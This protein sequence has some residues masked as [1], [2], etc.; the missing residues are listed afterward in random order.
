M[1]VCVFFVIFSPCKVELT[2]SGNF[3]TEYPDQM[4]VYNLISGDLCHGRPV[5]QKGGTNFLVMDDGGS[6][7]VS[8]RH[9][10][11]QAN[12]EGFVYFGTIDNYYMNMKL[13]TLGKPLWAHV[14]DSVDDITKD[15]VYIE[16]PNFQIIDVCEN[17]SNNT[18]IAG[19]EI[20]EFN[21]ESFWNTS[22]LPTFAGMYLS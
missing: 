10:C 17:T 12:S 2:S 13:P 21:L 5:W 7:V 18:Q 8:Q 14:G 15:D 1:F 20:Q 9:L 4:G 3:A 11:T 6:W 16:D 19:N 22:R